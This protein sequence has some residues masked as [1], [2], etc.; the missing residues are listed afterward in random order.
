MGQEPR[1]SNSLC[2][3]PSNSFEYYEIIVN[4]YLANSFW[5][6]DREKNKYSGYLRFGHAFEKS[7]F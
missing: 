7:I 6:D 2:R 3:I 5:Q 1:F 4:N